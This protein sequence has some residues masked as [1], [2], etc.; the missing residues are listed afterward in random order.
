M[1]GYPKKLYKSKNDRL[2]VHNAAEEAEALA[3]GFKNLADVWHLFS[4]KVPP[5]L[6]LP[7]EVHVESPPMRSTP[8][9]EEDLEHRYCNIF[10]GRKPKIR[11]SDTKHFADWK[12]AHGG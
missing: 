1:N 6:T 3:K 8:D 5:P 2:R 7:Q 9:T 4:G 12:R 11:G 10:C